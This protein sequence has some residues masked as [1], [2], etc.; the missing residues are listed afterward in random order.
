MLAVKPRIHRWVTIE[1]K[2]VFE[3]KGREHTRSARFTAY[4]EERAGEQVKEYY[5]SM[6]LAGFSFKREVRTVKP[7]GG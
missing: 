5:D 6:E 2:A 4:D 3:F 7:Y 1:I